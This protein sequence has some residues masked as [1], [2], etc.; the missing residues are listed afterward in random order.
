[1]TLKARRKVTLQCLSGKTHNWLAAPEFLSSK[2]ASPILF[3]CSVCLDT[4]D[5]AGVDSFSAGR[6]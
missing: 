1:M 3:Y 6:K 4:L 2:Y 5:E